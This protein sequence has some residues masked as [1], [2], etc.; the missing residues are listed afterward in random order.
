MLSLSF[1]LY[2]VLLILHRVPLRYTL[3]GKHHGQPR[4]G[5]R[6]PANRR[7]RLGI[8]QTGPGGFG[9]RT[10]LRRNAP[11]AD[12]QCYPRFA[13]AAMHTVSSLL[14]GYAQGDG[15]DSAIAR[16]AL[17]HCGANLI[18]WTPH[19]PWAD[20]KRTKEVVLEGVESLVSGFT[21]T[22]DTFSVRWWRYLDCTVYVSM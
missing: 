11:D 4:C 3:A 5:W 2:I 14:L 19:T 20:H 21:S 1:L 12:A 6:S 16:D 7:P 13:E 10:V 17:T 9:Y 18:I 15:G 22:E 8:G